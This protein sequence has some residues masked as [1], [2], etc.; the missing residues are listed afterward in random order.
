M[1]FCI[2]GQCKFVVDWADLL[3]NEKWSDLDLV[4]FFRWSPCS[5][6]FR[7]EIDF[8]PLFQLRCHFSFLIDI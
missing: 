2:L 8:I 3:R 5:E 6:V 4:Q 7:E 1:D